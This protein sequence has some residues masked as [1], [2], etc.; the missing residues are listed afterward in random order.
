MITTR[1]TVTIDAP[2]EAVWSLHLAIAAW[3][4]W[5]QGIDTAVIEGEPR[6]G[7]TFR[8]LTHGLDITSTI[9]AVDPGRSIG[10]SGPAAGID[11]IH[12]WTFDP[13]PG[14]GTLVTTEES[15]AGPPVDADPDALLTGLDASLTAWLAD[16]K[17]TAEARAARVAGRAGAAPR[18]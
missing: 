18:G 3:P 11:G 2:V 12:H 5:N 4:E 14:G 6:V 8:W 13:A 15:W 1:H 9:T 17:A 16:L 7:A 10:W